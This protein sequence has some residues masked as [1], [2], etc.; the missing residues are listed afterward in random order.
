MTQTFYLMRHTPITARP[1]APLRAYRG[2]GFD[3]PP[4]DFVYVDNAGGGDCLFH[5]LR[6]CGAIGADSVATARRKVAAYHRE[7]RPR[8]RFSPNLERSGVWGSTEDLELVSKVYGVRVYV[9]SEADRTWTFV[10]DGAREA[11]LWNRGRAT[12]GRAQHGHHWMA[13][14]PSA[15][16]YRGA[17]Q[18]STSEASCPYARAPSRARSSY[19]ARRKYGARSRDRAHRRTSM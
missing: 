8:G 2:V 13:L 1:H 4:I 18:R 6:Q 7:H 3:M 15:R 11:H 19:L 5:A 16:V 12:P 9:A 17:R 10:G 14:L